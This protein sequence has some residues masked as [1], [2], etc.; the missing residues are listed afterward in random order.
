M[1]VIYTNSTYIYDMFPNL[2][3]YLLAASATLCQRTARP[4][5]KKVNPKT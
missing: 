5:K 2:F 1:A 3:W 4:F